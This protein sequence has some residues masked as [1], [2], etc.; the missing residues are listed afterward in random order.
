MRDRRRVCA[1]EISEFWNVL[2]PGSGEL[3]WMIEL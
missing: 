1:H 3:N 2:R